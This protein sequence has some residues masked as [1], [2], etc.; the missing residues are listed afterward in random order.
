MTQSLEYMHT[1][2]LKRE[3]TI[4]AMKNKLESSPKVKHFLL[5]QKLSQGF[6]LSKHLFHRCSFPLLENTTAFP[7]ITEDII[8]NLTT[9]RNPETGKYETCY[10]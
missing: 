1:C 8:L 9:P 4:D 3:L 10:R 7:N 2:M 5:Y 6:Y